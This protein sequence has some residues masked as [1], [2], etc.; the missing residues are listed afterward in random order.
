VLL[1]GV[2]LFSSAIRA[3]L[4]EAKLREAAGIVRS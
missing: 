3:E 1:D 2:R 4:M